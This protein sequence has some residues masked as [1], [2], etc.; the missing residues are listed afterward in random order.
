MCK[1]ICQ[2]RSDGHT[3]IFHALPLPAADLGNP[4]LWIGTIVPTASNKQSKQIVSLLR[5]PL[6]AGGIVLPIYSGLFLKNRIIAQKYRLASSKSS[7]SFCCFRQKFQNAK[8]FCTRGR[9]VVLY[10]RKDERSTAK[11]DETGTEKTD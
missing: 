1:G 4:A 7:P 8:S 3:Y 2:A 10:Y 6:C 5:W 11:H 9:F